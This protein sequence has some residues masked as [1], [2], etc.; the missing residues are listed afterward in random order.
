MIQPLSSWFYYSDK[1]QP[2]FLRE[3]TDQ[4]VVALRR[5]AAS[6]AAVRGSTAW[7][8][9]I[10]TARESLEKVFAPLPPPNRQAPT[11]KVVETLVRPGYTCSKIL[12][13]TRPGFFVPAALWVPSNNKSADSSIGG[14]GGGS[15]GKRPG[16]LLV[17]GHTSDGFRSNNLNG[18]VQDNAL[19]D[20][21]YQVVQINLVSRGFVVLAFD[22][23]GQGERMQYV[24][25]TTHSANYC[26]IVSFTLFCAHS[27]SK[28]ECNTC[29]Q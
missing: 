17:S 15:A 6:V 24:C 7:K 18:P 4:S 8:E 29:R 27:F 10:A 13:E 5:R 11:Y 2:T 1:A 16:V 14:G 21:D 28:C 25:P 23:I 3:L 20:D 19:G 9:R 22:P 26:L 12:Y